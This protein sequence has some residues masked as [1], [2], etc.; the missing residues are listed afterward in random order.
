MLWAPKKLKRHHR[1]Q[2]QTV[3]PCAY[4]AANGKRNHLPSIIHVGE[5]A[6]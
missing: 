1:Y 3:N 6:A 4:V 5:M 2:V